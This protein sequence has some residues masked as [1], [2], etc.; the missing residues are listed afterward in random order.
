MSDAGVEFYAGNRFLGRPVAG[1]GQ[2]TF[3]LELHGAHLGPATELQVRAGGRRLDEAGV[4]AG[5]DS[6]RTASAAKQ[7]TSLPANPV[8]PGKPGRYRTVTGEYTLPSVRLPGFSAAVEMRV[9][10]VAP[11]GASGRRPMALFLHGRHET[12][13]RDG[14]DRFGTWSCPSGSKPVPSYARLLGGV[15]GP[16]TGALV[17]ASV[18]VRG[19]QDSPVTARFRSSGGA[20]AEDGSW[21]TLRPV[22]QNLFLISAT[23]RT[24]DMC[25]GR[26]TLRYPAGAYHLRP[27]AVNSPIR[28]RGGIRR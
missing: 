19:V 25:A 24:R 5:S 18:T 16:S 7:L 23:M 10:V 8:D 27:R 21:V 13:F 15:Q 2:R 9:V 14:V 12:C 17:G 26:G 1:K 22:Q 6:R 3:R 4:A 28:W 20:S 11:T